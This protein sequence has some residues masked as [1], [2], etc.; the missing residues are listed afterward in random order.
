MRRVAVCA[1][2]ALGIVGT[3]AATAMAPIPTSLTVILDFRGSHSDRSVKE[4][5]RETGAILKSTGL[6]LAWRLRD[7]AA[8]SA[9]SNLVVMTFKGSCRYDAAPREFNPSGPLAST[10][11]TDHIMQSFGQVDCDHVVQSA[12]SAMWAGDFA[13]ADMLVGRALGRVVTHE[14]VHML[15]NSR[16]HSR[17]GVFEEALSGRQLIAPSLPLSAMDVNLLMSGFENDHD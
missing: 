11:T 10:G 16:K 15:T 7:E 13:H 4:M 1:L 2:L 5:E 9:Y 17:D 12:R 3:L 14:L 6:K 8:S